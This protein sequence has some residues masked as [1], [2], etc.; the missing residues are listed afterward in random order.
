M[1]DDSF[2]FFSEVQHVFKQNSPKVSIKQKL[3][4]SKDQRRAAQI[5][6]GDLS[7]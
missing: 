6:F 4:S 5:K 2:Y 7:Q 1:E 3:N